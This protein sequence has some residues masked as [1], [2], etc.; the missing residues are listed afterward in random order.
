MKLFTLYKWI[1]GSQNDFTRQFQDNEQLYNQARLFWNNI[2]GSLWIVL[3]CALILGIG[4]AAYYYT[5]YNNVPG[6]HYKPLKWLIFL[7]ITF[8]VTIVI[9]VVIE[10]LLCDPKL[11]G[12]WNLELMISVGNSLY[13]CLIY[14]FT[15]V[16]WC[17]VGPTN[18]YRIFKI[19]RS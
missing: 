16:I 12:A 10:S 2:G 5:I 17:N 13:A 9:S 3:G 15:S 6:R 4:I 7:L 11:K 14:I 8:I 19:K 18:A 1:A